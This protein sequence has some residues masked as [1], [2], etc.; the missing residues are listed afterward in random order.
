MNIR[1]VVGVGNRKS[2]YTVKLWTSTPYWK[3]IELWI[4]KFYM[5]FCF[6][7]LESSYTLPK[8]CFWISEVLE[9]DGYEVCSN[10]SSHELDLN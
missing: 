2:E 9:I 10:S 5:E 7:S 1:K 4:S 6:N 3:S 8:S